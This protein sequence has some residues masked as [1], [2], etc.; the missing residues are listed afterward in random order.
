[1]GRERISSKDID[2]QIDILNAMFKNRGV[3][4]V[5]KSNPRQGYAGVDYYKNGYGANTLIC[6]ESNRTTY[7]RLQSMID[8][9]SLLGE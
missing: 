2:A 9:I 1:M 3:D 5:F 8:G 7:D 4:V 6:M